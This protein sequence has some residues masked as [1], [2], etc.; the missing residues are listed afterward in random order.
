MRGLYERWAGRG[1]SP[2]QNVFILTLSRSPF[3][4]APLCHIQEEGDWGGWRKEKKK[5][6]K[7]Q[8]DE[9]SIFKTREIC[10]RHHHH[11]HYLHPRSAGPS[12]SLFIHLSPWLV[13][14]SALYRMPDS[15][16]VACCMWW[17]YFY[18]R[19]SLYHQLPVY[20]VKYSLDRFEVASHFK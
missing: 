9:S 15:K 2:D 7:R 10:P 13:S 11:H 4:S 12:Y 19:V 16:A 18:A 20:T 14:R 8:W 6:G 17:G 3:K 1:P 5:G